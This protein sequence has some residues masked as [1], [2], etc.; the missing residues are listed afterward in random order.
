MVIG[1]MVIAELICRIGGEPYK[2]EYDQLVY[3][4]N[5]WLF[6]VTG[7]IFLCAIIPVILMIRKEK[8]LNEQQDATK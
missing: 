2:N 7:I 4:P 1:P 8:K 5:R 6:L 3:P